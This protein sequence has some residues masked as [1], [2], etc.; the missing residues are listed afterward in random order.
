VQ[1]VKAQLEETPGK[2]ENFIGG[3]GEVLPN[4]ENKISLDPQK[5]DQ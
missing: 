3:R 2:W 1:L 4:Y 5:K